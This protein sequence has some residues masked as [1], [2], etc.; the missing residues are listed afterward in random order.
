MAT[1]SNLKR[2]PASGRPPFASINPSLIRD[3]S[4]SMGISQSPTNPAVA[5]F[6]DPA[7]T[8]PVFRG[9]GMVCTTS[10]KPVSKDKEKMGSESS[11]ASMYGDNVSWFPQDRGYYSAPRTIEEQPPSYH[12]RNSFIDRE[13]QYAFKSSNGNMG[14]VAVADPALYLE[15]ATPMTAS[16]IDP[17]T[18]FSTMPSPFS[19]T[20]FQDPFCSMTRNRNARKI[21]YQKRQDHL[22]QREETL[23][24]PSSSAA[25]NRG[26][27][28]DMLSLLCRTENTLELLSIGTKIGFLLLACFS[29]CEMTVG[30]WSMLI[31]CC[32]LFFRTPS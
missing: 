21:P 15:E 30:R 5:Q 10:A 13:D 18:T 6:R 28:V 17:R 12:Q 23:R 31:I 19:F 24:K 9:G 1:F 20:S 3:E 16:L 27:E 14:A 2:A 11:I 29:S 7:C 4:P 26:N 22:L 32:A 25:I 8:P